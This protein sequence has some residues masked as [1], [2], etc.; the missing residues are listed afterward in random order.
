MPVQSGTLYGK[1]SMLSS[2][3]NLLPHAGI[4][5]ANKNDGHDVSDPLARKPKPDHSAK[6]TVN[7]R[8]ISSYVLEGRIRTRAVFRRKSDYTMIP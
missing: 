8:S 1:E 6:C 5:A 4:V 7:T 3:T 2:H